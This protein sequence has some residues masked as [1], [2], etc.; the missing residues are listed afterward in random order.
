M[1]EKTQLGS[2]PLLHFLSDQLEDQTENLSPMRVDSVI[3]ETNLKRFFFLLLFMVTSVAYGSSPA[4][5]GLGATAAAAHGNAGSLNP[6]S[7]PRD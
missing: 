2:I 1:G 6:L 3:L 7:K 5:G 4:R